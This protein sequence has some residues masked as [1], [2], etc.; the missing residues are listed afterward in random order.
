MAK[1]LREG[2][3]KQSLFGCVCGGIVERSVT[4]LMS[5]LVRRRRD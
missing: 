2:E 3:D 4:W 5:F 1:S